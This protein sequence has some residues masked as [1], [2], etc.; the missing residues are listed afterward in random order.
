ML[1][2]EKN[3]KAETEPKFYM[4]YTDVNTLIYSYLTLGMQVSTGQQYLEIFDTEEELSTA[5]DNLKGIGG[6]YM[7]NENR[8]PHPPNP[9]EW[10]PEPDPEPPFDDPFSGD[11][12]PQ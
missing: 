4:A 5:I 7:Q 8:I 6:W 2:S 1:L 9:N 3:Y 12:I 10:E 11:T